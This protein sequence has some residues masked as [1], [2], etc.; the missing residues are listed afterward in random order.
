MH[1]PR[2]LVFPLFYH[3]VDVQAYALLICGLPFSSSLDVQALVYGLWFILSYHLIFMKLKVVKNLNH[4][5]PECPTFR[6]YKS[7]FMLY[8]WLYIFISSHILI[9]IIMTILS[10]CDCDDSHNNWIHDSVRVCVFC[11]H[12][13]FVFVC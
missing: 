1:R 6:K 5:M 11:V 8:K 10:V 2:S 9:I 3:C 4:Y 13:F 7:E 12:D